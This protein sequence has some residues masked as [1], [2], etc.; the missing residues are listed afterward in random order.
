M[1]YENFINS[2]L[3]KGYIKKQKRNFDAV[4]KMIKRSY[5]DLK[6]AKANL[7]I[8]EGISFTIAYAAMLHAGRALMQL[9]GFRPSDGYQHR[10]VVDF[11]SVVLG[12]KYKNLINYYDNMRKKRNIFIYEVTISI[13]KMEAANAL[14]R[15]DEFVDVVVKLIKSENPQ[16]QFDF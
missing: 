15:A 12:E 13:S 6:T 14:G 4:E 5:K 2:Y 9:N 3:Q 11:V 1:N 16:K 8:D 10:T 7:D